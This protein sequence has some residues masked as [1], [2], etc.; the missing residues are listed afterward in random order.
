MKKQEVLWFLVFTIIGLIGGLALG[1][2]QG[3]GQGFADGSSQQ[4][5]LGNELDCWFH[6]KGCYWYGLTTNST[7]TTTTLPTHCLSATGPWEVVAVDENGTP[8]L[9]MNVT[10]N[11][12]G[13]PMFLV[14]DAHSC[15]YYGGFWDGKLCE[16]FKTC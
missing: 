12:S 7:T 1:H 5:V 15:E 4:V 9:K 6:D 10:T 2:F 16:D 11:N 8:R 14:G 3:Y 13:I